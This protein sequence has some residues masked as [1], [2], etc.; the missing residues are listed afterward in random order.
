MRRRSKMEEI[1]MPGGKVRLEE[2][3]EDY[4]AN[5]A[6]GRTDVMKAGKSPAKWKAELD[7]KER[8]AERLREEAWE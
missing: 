3:A 1:A 8:K 5:S 2:P 6:M 7:A 4:F